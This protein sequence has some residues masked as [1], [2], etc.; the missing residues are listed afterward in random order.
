MLLWPVLCTRCNEIT[1]AN[2]KETTLRC[3]ECRSD[4]VTELDS[5]DD[6]LK[7]GREIAV[8]WAQKSLLNSHYRCP[9]CRSFHLRIGSNPFDRFMSWD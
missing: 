9:K 1:T 2:F 7:D 8:Q 5:E 6:T 3:R 4:S